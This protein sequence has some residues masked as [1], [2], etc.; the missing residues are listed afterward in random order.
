M[1]DA[2]QLTVEYKSCDPSVEMPSTMGALHLVFLL[3][4]ARSLMAHPLR[5]LAATLRASEPY[6]RALGQYLGVMPEYGELT[7]VRYALLDAQRPFIGGNDR[8][9][10]DLE[11]DL[12]RQLALRDER[13]AMSTR[14]R[15]ALLELF[16]SGRSSAEEVCSHIGA[17]RSTMQRRLRE[18]GLSF[19]EVLDDTRKDLAVRYLSKSVLSNAEVANLLAYQDQSSF[20]RSFRRWT[21]TTPQKFRQ[22]LKLETASNMLKH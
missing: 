3:E 9:W 15:S 7:S 10:E 17:S 21:G 22:S 14:V 6:R 12:E 5:P 20:F 4:K 18:E 19:Q 13:S 11:Q 16:T 1:T 2:H 8:L